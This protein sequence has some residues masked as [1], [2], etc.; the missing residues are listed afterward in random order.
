MNLVESAEV[1]AARDEGRPVVALESTLVAHGLPW[2]DNLAVAR[3]LEAT[4]RQGGATPATI[5]VIDGSARIGLPDDVLEQLARD[6]SKLA[7]AGATDLAVHLARGSSAATTVSATAVLAARAG[8]RVFAT[9]GIGG[10]H[11]G[12]AADVSHDLVALARTAIIVVS[13][14]AK[15]ILDL[16]RTLELLETLGVLVIGYRTSELPAFYTRNSGLVLDHR[17]ETA[18]EIATIARRHWQLGGG[19][20]LACNPIPAHAELSGLEPVI[21]GALADAKADA[22]TGKRLTPFLLARLATVTAGASIRANRALALNNAEL[23]AA[24]ATAAG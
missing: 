5:A 22:I 15:A 17:A 20:V 9:G 13:A 4:V 10:V 14:G 8:I 2:P 1:V 11:R 6:G 3:E 18:E 21:D 7:K 16:P 24:I 23:A 12:D 19:G